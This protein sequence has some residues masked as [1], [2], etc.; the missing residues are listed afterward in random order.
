MISAKNIG[1]PQ[2]IRIGHDNSGTGPGWFL[3]EVIVTNTDTGASETFG[4]HRWLAEDEGDQQ[5]MRELVPGAGATIVKYH[6]RVKTGDEKGAG[7]DANVTIVLNGQDGK[8]TGGT[9]TGD[10]WQQF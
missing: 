8:N 10:R 2:K 9:K 4:C 6:V 7:T 5:T 3:E 1:V